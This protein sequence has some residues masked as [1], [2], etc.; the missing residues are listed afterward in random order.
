MPSEPAA[1][2]ADAG[3]MIFASEAG[4]CPTCFQQLVLKLSWAE[5]WGIF[6]FIIEIVDLDIFYGVW[7]LGGFGSID[8]ENT[9][10]GCG[11]DL[12]TIFGLLKKCTKI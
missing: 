7:H 2:V 11:C 8:S 4:S 10:T 1:S 9:A 3:R 6:N 5:L 12:L